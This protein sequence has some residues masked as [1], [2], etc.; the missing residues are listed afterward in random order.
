MELFGRDLRYALRT[1]LRTPGFSAI[2]VLIL[3]LGIGANSTIFTLAS[4]LFLGEPPAVEE[5]D[6]LVRIT[7]AQHGS[8]SHPLAYPDYEYFRD[9]ATTFDGIAAYNPT[10]ELVMARMGEEAAQARITYVSDN[11]FDVLGVDP[12]LGREFR[13]EE[14]REAGAHPVTVL[15]HGFWQSRY[16]GD[17]AAIGSTLRLNGHPFTVIGV[18]PPEFRGL[19]PVEMPP[20][21]WVPIHMFPVLNPAETLAFIERTQNDDIVWLHGVGRLAAGVSVQAA[22]AELDALA[23]TMEE[24]YPEWNEGRGVWVA[25]DY[26][27]APDTRGSLIEGVGLLAAVAFVVLLIACANLAILLLARAAGRGRELGVRLALGA[28]RSRLIRQLL[29]ESVVLAVAGAAAGL[30]IAAWS[31]DLAAALMPIRFTIEFNPNVRVLA[32]TIGLGL[33]TAVLFGLMPAWLATREDLVEVLKTSGTL[34]RHSRTR[35]ALVVTQL[36]LSIVLVSGAALFLRSLTAARAVE[37][38]YGSADRLFVTMNLANAGYDE[39]EGIRFVQEILRRTESLPGVASATT[40]RMLPLGGGKWTAGFEAEGV[41]PPAGEANWWAGTNSVG[42]G[43]FRTMGIPLVMGR[44]FMEREGPTAPAVA[45]VNEALARQIWGS[46]EAAMGRVISRGENRATV[47]GVA[48]DV[49]IYEL[50]ESPQPQLYLSQLQFYQPQVNLLVHARAGPGSAAGPLESALRELDPDLPMAEMRALDDLHA[51]AVGRYR[52]MA[53]MVGLFSGLALTLAAVGLYGVL[54]NTVARRRREIGIRMAL[55]AHREQVARAVLGDGMKLAV[56][57]IALGFAVAW[58]GS[59][60]VSSF[61]FGIAP[62]DPVAFILAPLI[63]LA[64]AAAASLLPA[65]RASRVEP[66]VTLRYE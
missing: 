62:R 49:V 21:I 24:L 32:L 46:P 6:R 43:Y 33:G 55:G 2:A 50:G 53:T 5:P 7:R 57:G 28:G 19:S 12:V 42:P 23:G 26:R 41:E 29:T 36:A 61:L 34:G 54:S 64:V 40:A 66:A 35:A 27:Y 65:R 48:R 30:V 51:N 20:D 13:P 15:R 8:I 38:G 4:S 45:V 52:L 16:G 31:A 63:L 58:L 25:S 39:E 22:R 9:H 11:Y 59:R 56:A 18:A 37:L 14:D 1:L 10:G 47:V 60:A 17:P 3:A 44:A